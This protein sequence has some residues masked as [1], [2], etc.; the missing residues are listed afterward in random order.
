MHTH[1]LPRRKTVKQPVSQARVLVCHA[2]LLIRQA[3]IFVRAAR[4]LVREATKPVHQAQ[5]LLPLRDHRSQEVNLLTHDLERLGQVT[6]QLG[7][8]SHELANLVQ[9]LLFAVDLSSAQE[10]LR[11]RNHTTRVGARTSSKG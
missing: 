6:K 5:E 9:T 8:L 1:K 11:S 3:R 4:A 2:H 10:Q 7:G